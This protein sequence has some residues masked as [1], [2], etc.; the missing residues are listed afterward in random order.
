MGFAG[1][2]VGVGGKGVGV[3]V[4]GN[5]VSDGSAVIVGGMEVGVEVVR[6]RVSGALHPG[7][8][9]RKNIMKMGKKD[10][11]FT[12]TSGDQEQVVLECCS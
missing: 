2:N 4:G 11:T 5:G 1:G 9:T 12:L 10:F 6:M 8:I 3:S 7:R